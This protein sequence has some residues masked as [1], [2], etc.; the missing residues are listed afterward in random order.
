[1]AS[2]PKELAGTAPPNNSSRGISRKVLFEKMTPILFLSWMVTAQINIIFGYETT[3]FSGVQSMPS[4]ATEFGSQDSS[5]KWALSAARASYTSSTAFA[6]KL[7]GSL[8]APRIIERLGHRWAIWILLI[9]VWIGIILESTSRHIEQFIVGRI[10]VYFSVGLAEVTST[11]YQSEISPASIRGTIVGSLQLF[12]LIGQILASGVNRGYASVEQRSGWIVPVAF[13]AAI[14]VLIFFGNFLIVD[15]PRWL[16]SK[17]RTEEAIEVLDRLRPKADVQAGLTRREVEAIR[18]VIQSD[19]ESGSWVQL[20][21]GVNLRRTLIA[22]S[23]L[24]LQQLCGQGFVSGY[25]P[26]FYDSVGLS[27]EAF[28]YNIGSATL[29]WGG[30]LL[31]MLLSDFIGRRS[32]LIWG[33]IGQMIFLFVVAGLGLKKNP[34]TSEANGLVAGVMLYFFIYSG[35]WGP[36]AFTVAAEV[37]SAPLRAKT[38]SLGIALKYIQPSSTTLAS[39]LTKYTVANIGW[40]FG[41]IAFMCSVLVYFVLPETK[42]RSLEELDELFRSR[43]PARKF[44]KTRTCGPSSR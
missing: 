8:V 43:V 39:K 22:S 41:A 38:L 44:E 19:M 29:G 35:T 18:E 5:G 10:V 21:E 33:G 9:I 24:F 2:L 6:G 28:N 37:G 16:I 30:C 25:S 4:F 12:N 13:Q 42:N 23:L 1:M 36:L 26:K 31:G 20:F 3:S 34:T 15:S 40:V 27:S 14:P 11:G 17:D 7:I 32:V